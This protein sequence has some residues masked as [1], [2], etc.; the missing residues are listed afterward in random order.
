MKLLVELAR[1][2]A[3]LRDY[4]APLHDVT[5][6]MPLTEFLKVIWTTRPYCFSWRLSCSL[7]FVGMVLLTW[8]PKFLYDKFHFEPRRLG[9]HRNVFIQLASM[10]RSLVGGWLADTRCASA[11][12][13]M[14]RSPDDRSVWLP[15]HL[16]SGAARRFPFLAHY[17][18]DALGILQGHVR[19]EHFRGD[20]R[21]RAAEGPGDSRWIHEYDRLAGGCCSVPVLIGY[22]ASRSSL[23]R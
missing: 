7:C 16:S 9:T 18:S 17:E 21:C 4:G 15:R 10:G 11:S 5:Q 22:I 8:M 3:D 20:A 14:Y 23:G 19:L 1:G 12:R 13:A 2:A 6:K